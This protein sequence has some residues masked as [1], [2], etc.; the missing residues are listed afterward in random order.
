MRTKRQ[1]M[2]RKTFLKRFGKKRT[3]FIWRPV[4]QKMKAGDA[5]AEVEVEAG[6]ETHRS[7]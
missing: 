3:V 2:E 6:A 4:P 7:R 1:I 5:A